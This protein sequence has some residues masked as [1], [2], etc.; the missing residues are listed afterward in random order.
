MKEKFARSFSNWLQA[1]NI[2]VA[3]NPCKPVN[4]LVTM[5]N[6]VNC[7][8]TKLKA[9]QLLLITLNSVGINTRLMGRPSNAT[10]S[11]HSRSKGILTKHHL[12]ILLVV[13][14]ECDTW[15][16]TIRE[17]RRLRVFQNRVL[18]KIFCPRSDEVIQEWRKL[19]NKELNELYSS[20]NTVRAII[21]KRMRWA[22]HVELMGEWRGVYRV[23]V[24][25]LEG[26]RPLGRPWH[27][28]ENNI[29]IYLQ[30][31]GCGCTE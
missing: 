1:T 6:A 5:T 24:E 8:R 19:H 16:L 9:D 7:N 20:P 26:R 18:R 17:E 21:P 29:K 31:A 15:S 3:Y 4:K 30:E 27:R 14:Y 13:L 12:L 28:W 10:G 22:G 25:K 2:K 23:L 11:I